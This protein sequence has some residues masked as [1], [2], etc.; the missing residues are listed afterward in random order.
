MSDAFTAVDLRFSFGNLPLLR[1]V[2]FSVAHGGKFVIAGRS[3]CGKSTLLEL[4]ASLRCSDAGKVLW[5]GVDIAELTKEALV[6]ARQK[7]GYVF[8]RH[9]LV[10]NITVFDNIA[11]P[12][13]YHHR[14]TERDVRA[15]V[16][17]VM[18]ELG[19]FGVDKKFPYELSVGQ[20]RC[21]A[22]ARALVME[23]ALLFMDEPTAGAD[24]VTADGIT[25][26]LNEIN[27]YRHIAIILVCNTIST[28]KKLSCPFKVL[29]NGV[30]VDHD[31]P[32]FTD[33]SMADVF[34]SLRSEP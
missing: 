3:G 7:I 33:S 26:V 16:K 22:I 1:G 34:S 21:A 12:L 6:T 8:Q 30:L 10:H 18:D 4:C 20:S 17:R 25:N 19:L 9:A 14:G 15:A 27:T 32:S 28:I 29:E 2:S 5:Q 11:L 23:P 24:P 13:R 31:D